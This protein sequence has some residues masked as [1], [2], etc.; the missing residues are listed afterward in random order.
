MAP[1]ASSRGT[2]MATSTCDGSTAPVEQAEP[3]E[4]ATPA[5][6]RCMSSASLSAPATAT[7]STCGARSAPSPLTTRSG[8]TARSRAASSSRSARSRA[9]SA[10]CSAAAS[11]RGAPERHRAGHVLGAGP[12]AVLLAAAVDDRLDGLAVAHDQR[13]DALGRAD[14]VA[15]RW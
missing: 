6:S 3:P 11:V 13:A 14:L 9:A 7:L 4:A 8:T 2:P 1:S 10:G 12:D 5:R 15:R